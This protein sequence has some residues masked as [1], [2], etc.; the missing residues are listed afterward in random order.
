M[1]DINYF[2]K[3][4]QFQKDRQNRVGLLMHARYIT[5]HVQGVKDCQLGQLYCNQVLAANPITDPALLIEAAQ[6]L[7]FPNFCRTF[8][9][10]SNTEYIYYKDQN[11]ILCGDIVYACYKTIEEFERCNMIDIACNAEMYHASSKQEY[12][13]TMIELCKKMKDD[14]GINHF[15]IIQNDDSVEFQ[16]AGLDVFHSPHLPKGHTILAAN[17]PDSDSFPFAFCPYMLLSP[18]NK[19]SAGFLLNRKMKQLCKRII[20][21]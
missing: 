15:A 9:L 14:F 8:V 5:Q 21:Q 6:K 17:D 11:N 12:R 20:L 10:S 4:I 13:D 16:G 1:D 2:I 18:D 7:T 19:M 3:N